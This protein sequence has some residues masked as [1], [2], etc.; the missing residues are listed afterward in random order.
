MTAGASSGAAA[1]RNA[2]VGTLESHLRARRDAGRKLLVPY[3]TGGMGADWIESVHAVADAG[4]DAVEI[5]IPFSDP[6]ID[7]PT[8]Q[9]ASLRAL[10]RGTTPAS[11]LDALARADLA[12]PLCVMT[13]YNIV[14]RAGLR[15]FARSLADAGVAG[16]IIPDLPLEEAGEWCV[17]ADDAGVAT[18]LLVAPSTPSAR[19]SVICE[20]SRG[21]VYGVGIMGVTGER[22]ALAS[23]AGAV[24]KMLRLLTDR[25][26]CI[27]IGVSTPAQAAEACADADGV[28]VGS[29]IVRRLLDGAGPE[30]AGEFVG[31]LRAGIDARAS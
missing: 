26:V 20:R 22:A 14:F 27:G 28:V 4:A 31:S 23:T 9:E 13:Y 1:A 7:G 18:V 25:P 17:E 15:R 5:G 16:A 11:V 24:G 6:M 30:G 21:F 29:A 12:V 19:A 2:G 8:I 3:V 10:Q